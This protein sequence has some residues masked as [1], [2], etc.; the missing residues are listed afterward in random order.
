MRLDTER[1]QGYGEYLIDGFRVNYLYGLDEL[2]RKYVKDD[3]TILELG[4]NDGVSTQV[5]CKYAKSVVAVDIQL[6][7]N[8]SNVLSINSNLKF[9]Q[10]TFR[11]FY[12]SVQ[13]K[14]DLIYIDGSHIYSDVKKDIDSCLSF[15]KPN[16]YLCGHDYNSSCQGV[17]KAVNDSFGDVEVFD[18]SSWLKKIN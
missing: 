15:L 17:V 7:K 10:Q 1:M 5:F 4:V 8:F 13:E 14:F 18:D 16:G 2:C 11:E 9:H 12:L 6:T 3:F